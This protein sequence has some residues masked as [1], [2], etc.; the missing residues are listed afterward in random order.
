MNRKVIFSIVAL[1]LLA[2]LASWFW[3]SGRLRR[4]SPLNMRAGKMPKAPQLPPSSEQLIAQALRGKEI[5]YETSIMYRVFALFG[6]GRLP[7]KYVSE[8]FNLDAGTALFAEIHKNRDR[9]SAATL[10]TLAPFLARPNDPKS[11]LYLPRSVTAGVLSAPVVHAASAWANLPAANGLVR[12]WT[13]PDFQLPT[14]LETYVGG[15]NLVWP[16]LRKLIRAPIP[17]QAGDPSA[18]VNP[19]SAIDIYVLPV[20]QINPRQ[21]GCDQHPNA[22]TC[23]FPNVGGLT[24]ATPPISA[25]HSSSAYILISANNFDDFLLGVLAHELYH[26]SQ[27]AYN[28]DTPWLM[29]ST[30]TWAQFRVLQNLGRTYTQVTSFLPDFFSTLNLTPLDTWDTLPSTHQYGAY[31][32][33]LFAQME[34]GDSVVSD[35]WTQ[36]ATLDGAA[37]VDA[38]FPFKDHFRDFALRNWNR[39]PVPKLYSTADPNFPDL[40]PT[41]YPIALLADHPETLNG[42]IL[43]L[44]AD[45]YQVAAIDENI[46]KLRFDFGSLAQ[47]ENA[48]VDAIVTIEKKSPEVRHWTGQ[49]QVTFCR[50]DADERITSFILIISNADLEHGLTPPVKLQPYSKPCEGTGATLSMNGTF[51]ADFTG[52]SGGSVCQDHLLIKYSGSARYE[53]L[54]LGSGTKN[55]HPDTLTTYPRSGVQSDRSGSFPVDIQGGGSCQAGKTGGSITWRYFANPSELPTD[56]FPSISVQL[57]KGQFSLQEPSSDEFQAEGQVNIPGRAPISVSPPKLAALALTQLR[58]GSLQKVGDTLSGTFTPFSKQFSKSNSVTDS[59]ETNNP[60]GSRSTASLSISY[61]LTVHRE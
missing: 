5:D 37:A 14:P 59:V 27:N 3:R 21:G 40:Q 56:K 43:Y 41:T 10:N 11:I 19:D 34:R 46:A 49:R 8:T 53:L 17:D 52:N 4:P 45:Y 28:Y 42:N 35:V 15:V 39:D 38:A 60:D 24:F 25:P 47:N 7:A 50:D 30:A 13:S 44:T 36:A 16:E 1:V 48:G 26:A 6:D 61:S 55:I 31:L 29:E 22:G 2:G 58:T 32:Y 33:F 54:P 57:Q 18:D 12:V 9:L 20:G 23:A 51:T